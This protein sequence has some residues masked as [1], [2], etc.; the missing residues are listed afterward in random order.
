[1]FIRGG[2]FVIGDFCV[3]VLHLGQECQAEGKQRA[4]GADAAEPEHQH[5]A[6]HL[7]P[8]VGDEVYDAARQGHVAGSIPV[9]K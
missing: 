5:Q 9:A 4:D 7:A 6:A 2:R 3:E 8:D 1:M